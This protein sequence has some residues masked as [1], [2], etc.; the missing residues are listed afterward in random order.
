[1]KRIYDQDHSYDDE[2]RYSPVEK[3]AC[4]RY[5]KTDMF[6]GKCN[7]KVKYL[8]IRCENCKGLIDW[9]KVVKE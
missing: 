4:K 3:L 1:M 9:E 5:D 6:C 8:Q 2:P 7:A